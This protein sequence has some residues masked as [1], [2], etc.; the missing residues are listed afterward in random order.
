MS[1]I[2]QRIIRQSL[3]AA[4]GYLVAKGVINADAAGSWTSAGV[5]FF[6]ALALFAVSWIWST[7]NAY[8]LSRKKS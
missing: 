4:A 3:T 6:S 2:I 7:M 8:L 1:L 5:E